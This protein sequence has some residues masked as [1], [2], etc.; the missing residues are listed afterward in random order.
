[1]KKTLTVNLNNIVFHIDDDAY[2][3][4]QTYLADVEKHLS[5]DE[6]KEVMA[7]IEARVAELFT[8]RLQRTKNVVNLEDVEEIIN[9]L[10][11]PSQYG[12]T[13][14]E[15]E[16]QQSN[17]TERKRARRFYRDQDRA[18][19][20]G[21]AAGL[22]SFLGW[23]ITL[24]RIIFVVLV[25]LGVGMMI[26]IYLLVWLIAPAALTAAQRLEM[27]GEDVTAENIKTE[28]NNVK[29]YMESEKFKQSAGRVGSR[30][31]EILGVIFKAVFGFVGAVLGFAGMIVLGV[32][33]LVL[34]V[35][36]FEPASITGFAPD[37]LQEWTMLTP[38]KAILLVIA[39]L[40]V[41]GCPIF[42]LVYWIIR[43][44]NG[45]HDNY[46]RTT[47]WIVLIL[48]L[49]GLFM[50]YSI[51]ART[52]IHWSNTNFGDVD[53][54][55]HEDESSNQSDQRTLSTFNA[56]GASGNIELIISQDSVQEVTV[57][58]KESIMPKVITEVENGVLKVYTQKL[59]V[60]HRVKVYV[61]VDSLVAVTAKGACEVK[62]DE[63][64]IASNFKLELVGASD[65]DMELKVKNNTEIN[66]V[67]ASSVDLRGNTLN[68]KGEATGASKIDADEFQ[69][70][71]ADVSAV[72]A[73][74]TRVFVT[75]KIDARATGASHIYCKGNPKHV[76]KSS[77]PGSSIDVE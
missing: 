33:I 77:H 56:I 36:I 51:G 74:E 37:M 17:R 26:P 34:L 22:A 50:F 46:N 11:K 21:V 7:D 71:T 28:I 60:N 2:E 32:L 35:L 19:L 61:T 8:E 45:R 6:R 30:I 59:Y 25:F 54:D 64:I 41:I 55:W 69:S 1:M 68:I 9:I 75:E 24:V 12:V 31:G 38:E 66:V 73:S 15:A 53:I 76:S 42:M 29:N 72:G 65:A 62:T 16:N 57:S 27:Q 49:A 4:L 63:E 58:A 10:G 18:V 48:W 39:L 70:Q 43:L 52:F 5:E 13:E 67:G 44:V 3:M 20:G 40:L 23:D 14:E 47:S